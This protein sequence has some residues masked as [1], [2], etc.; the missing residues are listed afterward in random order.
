MSPGGVS[1]HAQIT[2]IAK[3]EATSVGGTPAVAATVTLNRNRKKVCAQT[4][5]HVLSLCNKTISIEKI[6]NSFGK[7]ISQHYILKQTNKQ[8]ETNKQ[9]QNQY[10]AYL[11]L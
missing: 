1:T 4:V 6:K 7:L 3:P 10:F 9:Q 5:V 2:V 8:I 11:L